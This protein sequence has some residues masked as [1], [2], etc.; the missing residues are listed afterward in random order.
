MGNYSYSNLGYNIAAFIVESLWSPPTPLE[1]LVPKV[2]FSGWLTG[3]PP[4]KWKYGP[5]SATPYATPA[6]TAFGHLCVDGAW[7]IASCVHR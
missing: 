6:T 2:L 7:G 4:S 3:L 1:Q 5:V